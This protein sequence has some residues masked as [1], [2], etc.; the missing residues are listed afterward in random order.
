[1]NKTA[2]DRVLVILLWPTDIWGKESV[3]GPNLLFL[4]IL[5]PVFKDIFS[6]YIVFFFVF[7][8]FKKK[9]SYTG[10]EKRSDFVCCS[11]I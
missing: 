3:Y 11:I 4:H 5:P 8:F 7:F 1:M 6:A 2:D 10:M 9:F